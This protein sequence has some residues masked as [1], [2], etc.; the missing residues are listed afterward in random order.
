MLLLLLLLLLPLP[1]HT[2]IPPPCKVSIFQVIH[3]S[4]IPYFIIDIHTSLIFVWLTAVLCRNFHSAWSW[5]AFPR[6]LQAI[7][8]DSL[9]C[10]SYTLPL[11]CSLIYRKLLNCTCLNQHRR[12]YRAP[13]REGT[14]PHDP[15]IFFP[16]SP[17]IKPLVSYNV[18]SSGFLEPK[19]FCTVPLILKKVCH[20]SP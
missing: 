19:S 11:R 8:L 7:I 17:L 10:L 2:F 14:C 1:N 20:F 6:I 9:V 15:L 3:Y 5:H 16:C 12:Y 13:S 4:W 18:W